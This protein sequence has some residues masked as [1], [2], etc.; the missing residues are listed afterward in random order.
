MTSVTGVDRVLR[1]LAKLQKQATQE[2]EPEQAK[3]AETLKTLAQQEAPVQ[4]GELRD[5][6]F[7]DS[8]YRRGNAVTVEMGFSAPYAA[9]V[10]EGTGQGRQFLLKAVSDNP[11][12]LR[13]A[14]RRAV[15]GVI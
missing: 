10:H 14:I 12:V 7:V 9:S 2:L 4:T 5:S 13:D 6:A 1:N 3:A 8:P 15:Q 11:E